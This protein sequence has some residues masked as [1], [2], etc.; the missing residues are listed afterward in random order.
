MNTRPIKV[1]KNQLIPSPTQFPFPLRIV[2]AF[3]I[4]FRF[5]PKKYKKYRFRDR[6]R[7]KNY[8]KYRFHDRFGYAKLLLPTLTPIL[9]ENLLRADNYAEPLIR[10]SNSLNPF[11]V[12]KRVFTINFITKEVVPKFFNFHISKRCAQQK[13]YTFFLSNKS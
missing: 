4:R 13:N 11:F 6:F 9:T 2:E 5:R 7:P 3:R 1:T 8:K 10:K 12:K